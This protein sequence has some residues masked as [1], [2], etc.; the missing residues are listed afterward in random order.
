MR[1]CH[2]KGVTEG[3]S[4]SAIS[5]GA[6][7]LVEIGSFCRAGTAC[8][9]CLPEVCR[10]LDD[11]LTG[12]AYY[13]THGGSPRRDRRAALPTGCDDCPLFLESDE[14]GELLSA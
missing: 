8:G 14:S 5:A 10:L 4:R 9:G 12:L 13:A 2:C 11:Y 7:T 1:V 3:Q 6:R